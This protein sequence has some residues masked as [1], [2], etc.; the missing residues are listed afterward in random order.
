VRYSGAS[1]GYQ[2]G[3][4]FGGGLAPFITAS[5]LSATGT[6]W[7]VAGYIDVLAA[8]SIASIVLLR[9]QANVGAKEMT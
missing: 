4:V 5:L 3:T 1:L 8:I 2:V 6:S 7:S 9:H